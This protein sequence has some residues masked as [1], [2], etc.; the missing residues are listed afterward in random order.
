MPLGGSFPGNLGTGT[1]GKSQAGTHRRSRH[2]ERRARQ[3]QTTHQAGI[4]RQ[5]PGTLAL[6]PFLLFAAAWG[7]AALCHTLIVSSC[8]TIHVMNRRVSVRAIALHEGKLLCVKLKQY[9]QLAST[10]DGAWCIPGGTLEEGEALIQGL[11]REMTEE[12]GI[13]PVVGNLL[14]VQQFSEKDKNKEHLE[15]FFHVTN[16][17]DYLDID[18]AQTSHGNAEIEQIAFVDPAAT[19]ILPRF[20]GTEPLT[21]HAAAAAPAKI[22]SFMA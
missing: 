10:M 1:R 8:A 19:N 16:A 11:E 21:Q 15:F 12:T 17:E 7:F 20:L 4:P 18:L 22:F 2:D 6:A 9:N 13:K 14:Y 5:P 3:G